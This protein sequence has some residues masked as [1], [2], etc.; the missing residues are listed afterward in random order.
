MFPTLQTD[1]RH[2]QDGGRTLKLL[3]ALLVIMSARYLEKE[4]RDLK[5]I[6]VVARPFGNNV[7]TTKRRAL[8]LPLSRYSRSY[9]L[10]W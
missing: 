6:Y 10:F 9:D 4:A 2:S 1:I 7:R 8:L 3:T 5:Q